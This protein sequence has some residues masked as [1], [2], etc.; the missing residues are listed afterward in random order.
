MFNIGMGELILIVV[1]ALVVLGPDK[2]P[3]TARA[4]GKAVRE[5]KR[6]MNSAQLDLNDTKVK[7]PQKEEQTHEKR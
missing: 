7:A 2:L 5:F 3:E 6:A 4:L 1:V